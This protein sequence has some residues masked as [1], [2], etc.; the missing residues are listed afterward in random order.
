MIVRTK[1]ARQ[2]LGHFR[3][4]LAS[5]PCLRPAGAFLPLWPPCGAG[6][7]VPAARW[8]LNADPSKP[9]SHSITWS[10]SAFLRPFF[11]TF[12]T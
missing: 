4:F 6:N 3:E 8:L 11:S 2:R 5:R 10:C 1:V 12:V 9:V 7:V